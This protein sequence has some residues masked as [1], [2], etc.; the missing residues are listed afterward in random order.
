MDPVSKEEK[1]RK[2]GKYTSYYFSLYIAQKARNGSETK[3]S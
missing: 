1:K 3:N 2:K